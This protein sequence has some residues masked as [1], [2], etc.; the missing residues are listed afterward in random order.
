MFVPKMMRGQLGEVEL[1]AKAYNATLFFFSMIDLELRPTP[2]TNILAN[3]STVWIPKVEARV[4]LAWL[5]DFVC[6]L[7]VE[8]AD[9]QADELMRLLGQCLIFAR[10][11]EELCR[12]C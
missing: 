9:L 12:F 3:R 10:F 6:Q 7:L 1:A 5:S 4:V 8:R 2:K 11:Q